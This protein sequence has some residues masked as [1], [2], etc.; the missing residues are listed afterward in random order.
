MLLAMNGVC[1]CGLVCLFLFR[2]RLT[3]GMLFC[4]IVLRVVWF[5]CYLVGFCQEKR[6]SVDKRGHAR[7]IR[8]RE[9]KEEMERVAVL[10]CEAV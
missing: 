7:M 2:S 6:R 9:I 8:E 10:L 3:T 4:R 1:L 5:C